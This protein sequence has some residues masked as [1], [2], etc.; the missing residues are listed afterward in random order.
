M[1]SIAAWLIVAG[2][3]GVALGDEVVGTLILDPVEL[4]R[5]REVVGDEGIL[6]THYRFAYLFASE[7]NKAEFERRPEKYEI[8]LGGAC[9][10]M[11]ALV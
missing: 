2:W 3:G 10:R 5:G 6:A 11:G 8:Q 4:V 1:K 7:K 9:G